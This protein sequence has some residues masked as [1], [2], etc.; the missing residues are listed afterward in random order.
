MYFM[1]PSTD[2]KHA[3][4]YILEPRFFPK[5]FFE[6]KKCFSDS[7]EIPNY[8]FLP[9]DYREFFWL[10]LASAVENS[11]DPKFHLPN[12]R[13][14][15]GFH[16]PSRFFLLNLYTKNR[17]QISE[18]LKCGAIFS[19]DRKIISTLKPWSRFWIAFGNMRMVIYCF[20]ES[21]FASFYRDFRTYRKK[22]HN[23]H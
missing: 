11:S 20:P 22:T 13:F 2:K 19:A 7:H 5:I 9:L 4:K 12:D 6:P 23:F 21:Y 3:E 16:S 14:W 10:L 8:T 18:R 15:R 17:R 1:Q